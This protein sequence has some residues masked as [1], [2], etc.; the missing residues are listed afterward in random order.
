M[1]RL[2]LSATGLIA[3]AVLVACGTKPHELVLVTP[4]S[5]IDREI[6]EDLS[7]LF[8]NE[9]VLTRIR[10]TDEQL[11]GTAALDALVS[12]RADIAIVSK[13]RKSVV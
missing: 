1:T 11:P 5:E 6:V 4:S 9:R 12:G 10:L 8:D 3:A 13:D 2:I 7:E